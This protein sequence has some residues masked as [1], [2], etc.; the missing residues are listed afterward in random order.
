MGGFGT[1]LQKIVF[2]GPIVWQMNDTYKVLLG[3]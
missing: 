3:W 1:K 2:I